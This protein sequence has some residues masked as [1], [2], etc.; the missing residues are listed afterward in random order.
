VRRTIQVLGIALMVAGL[1]IDS[2][3]RSRRRAGATTDR[4]LTSRLP[5]LLFWIG[6]VVLVLAS[7]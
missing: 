7:I 1:F 6:A 2:S 5:L 3:A 4:D